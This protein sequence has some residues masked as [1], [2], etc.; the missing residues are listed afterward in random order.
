MGWNMQ[1][2]YDA[3]WEAADLAAQT[4]EDA[5]RAPGLIPKEDIWQPGEWAK[6]LDI[7][8]KLLAKR[9][10]AQQYRATK[11]LDQV[12][13][14]IQATYTPEGGEKISE[15]SINRVALSIVTV[16]VVY[17]C[18]PPELMAVTDEEKKQILDRY[19]E[20]KQLQECYPGLSVDTWEEVKTGL[21]KLPPSPLTAEMDWEFISE[22]LVLETYE[23][24][25]V[26]P[27]EKS[28]IERLIEGKQKK[29]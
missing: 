13:T 6:W 11:M 3:Q 25:G 19:W 24:G 28:D 5:I 2:T 22:Q 27:L 4:R 20:L 16:V 17:N 21:E 26:G 9:Q 18:L 23:R 8:R 1:R 10:D 14:V 12:K 29:V 15:D 7:E